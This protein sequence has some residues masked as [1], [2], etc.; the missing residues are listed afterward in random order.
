[1]NK[2]I[3]LIVLLL[4]SISAYGQL[5]KKE[6]LKYVGTYKSSDPQSCPITLVITSMSEGYHYNMKIK[7]KEKT[8]KLK[9]AKEKDEVCLNF[10]G[11]IGKQPKSVVEG[12]YINNSVVI[13][14][15]GN[16]M[17]K[18]LVFNECKD[19]KYI[20]LSKVVKK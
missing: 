20:E 1:M 11:L 15:D 4:F 16:A 7:A 6:N 13:Q 18:F 5:S 17:N 14:N 2:K 3:Y 19:F 12:Q 8:G 9:I 10:T